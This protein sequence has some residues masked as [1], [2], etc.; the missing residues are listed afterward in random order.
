MKALCKQQVFGN[1]PRIHSILFIQKV[2][3]AG[4]YTSMSLRGAFHTLNFQRDLKIMLNT[5]KPWWLLCRCTCCQKIIFLKWMF[6][7]LL[8]IPIFFLPSPPLL[9]I[10]IFQSPSPTF[11][12]VH[13]KHSSGWHLFCF[14]CPK[15]IRISFWNSHIQTVCNLSGAVIPGDH[16]P[17]LKLK[18]TDTCPS[19]LS[20]ARSLACD[21]SVIRC[22]FL[23]SDCWTSDRNNRNV[24]KVCTAGMACPPHYS[25]LW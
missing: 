22:S 10:L 3:S 11:Q 6:P 15:N 9:P 8:P 13:W 19:W 16:I 4:D 21:P 20:R 2:P 17:L 7:A 23:Y 25:V 18:E 12:L 14:D 1:I 24:W 5:Q